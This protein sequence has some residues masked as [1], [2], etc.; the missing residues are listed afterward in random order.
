MPVAG[1]RVSINQRSRRGSTNAPK[2]P[3]ELKN[4][5]RSGG[6]RRNSTSM[7]SEA[8]SKAVVALDLSVKSAT[9]LPN[10]TLRAA[11]LFMGKA[12]DR[13]KLTAAKNSETLSRRLNEDISDPATRHLHAKRVRDDGTVVIRAAA[14]SNDVVRRFKLRSNSVAGF[15]DEGSLQEQASALQNVS[16]ER[17]ARER[18]LVLE[19]SK[20]WRRWQACVVL[21]AAFEAFFAPVNWSLNPHLSAFVVFVDLFFDVVYLLDFVMQF[22]LA[23]KNKKTGLLIASHREIFLHYCRRMFF[24]DIFICLPL[25]KVYAATYGLYGNAANK[26]MVTQAFKFFRC[27]RPVRF[28]YLFEIVDGMDQTK[29]TWIFYSTF[30]N[31]MKVL[32][33]LSFMVVVFHYGGCLWYSI[34]WIGKEDGWNYWERAGYCR[35]IYEVNELKNELAAALSTEAAPPPGEEIYVPLKTPSVCLADGEND[36]MASQYDTSILASVYLLCVGENLSPVTN[37]EKSSMSVLLVA[38]ALLMAFIFG[39]IH[40]YVQNMLQTSSDYQKKMESVYDAM[41]RMKLPQAIQKRIFFFYDHLFREHGTLD[42]SVKGFVPEV[43]KKLRSEIYLWQRYEMI[44]EVPFFKNVH[45]KVVEDI[46]VQLQ[47]E[48]YLGGD[49][50]VNKEDFGDCMYFIYTGEVE[51]CVPRTNDDVV[52]AAAV[53]AQRDSLKEHRGSAPLRGS[54]RGLLARG[55]SIRNA[56]VGVVGSGEGGGAPHRA[57]AV[58]VPVVGGSAAAAAA[59]AVEEQQRSGEGGGGGVAGAG[60]G[61]PQSSPPKKKEDESISSGRGERVTLL[62]AK[63]AV[64]ELL[65]IAGDSKKAAE[66]ENKTPPQYIGSKVVATLKAGQ[67]FGEVALIL[68]GKRTASIRAKGPCELCVLTREMYDFVATAYPE[69]AVMMRNVILSKY[70][71]LEH[72][73]TSVTDATTGKAAEQHR[74]FLAKKLK[75]RDDVQARELSKQQELNEASAQLE[76]VVHRFSSDVASVNNMMDSMFEYEL[77]SQKALDAMTLELLLM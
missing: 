44:K 61:Y 32:R 33:L 18:W 37:V 70:G 45:S 64:V 46:V 43:S 59:A 16:L 5:T 25:D 4:E 68:Q 8:S 75:D 65:Q 23:R 34:A 27:F 24:L 55:A 21:I 73:R 52:K 1:V 26:L 9:A 30:S 67:Y 71:A 29:Q 41:E 56:V 48:L 22:H 74:A 3:A 11:T 72:A 54:V 39:S 77:Q 50:I 42:G 31:K 14:S 62:G 57:S 15:H 17:E 69:D 51:V 19:R 10:A 38:G 60:T 47:A 20:A 40:S 28:V 76:S 12:K 63:K 49:L 2:S 66:A 6:E 53:N 7:L 13:L 58:V 36:D 35:N